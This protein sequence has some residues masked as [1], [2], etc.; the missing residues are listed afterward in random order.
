M[1]YETYARK[2][3]NKKHSG[4]HYAHDWLE[5]PAMRE[6]LPDL[7]GKKVLCIG[8]GSGEECEEFIKLG[9]S[10]V[11]GLDNSKGLIEQ[12]KYMHPDVEFVCQDAQQLSFSDQSFDFIYSSL[13]LHYLKN[14]PEFFQRLSHILI[15]NGMF[16]FSTHHPVKWGAQTERSKDVNEFKLGYR[17]IKQDSTFETYGDYLNFR[18]IKDTLFGEM[19]IIHYHRSMSQMY[20]EITENGFTVEKIIEPKPIDL[21][22]Q[23]PD[24]YEVYS[25]IPLFIMFEVRGK[26]ECA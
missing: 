20:R 26:S 6:L 12:A 1:S 15:P 11:V 7:S 22:R 8:C 17:K 16:L 10:Q 24:F 9:A 21:A 14:W 23:K 2:W 25:K 5:K 13:T 19:D 4:K 18:P 3:S